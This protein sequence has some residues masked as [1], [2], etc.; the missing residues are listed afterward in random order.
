MSENRST[1]SLE[2]LLKTCKREIED[3]M[4]HPEGYLMRKV[5]ERRRITMHKFSIDDAVRDVR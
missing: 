1:I 5:T 3:A 4:E 2:N